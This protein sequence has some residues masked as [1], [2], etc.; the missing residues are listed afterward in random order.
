[1]APGDVIKSGPTVARDGSPRRVLATVGVAVAAAACGAGVALVLTSD[2]DVSA[3]L[4]CNEPLPGRVL[5]VNLSWAEGADAVTM[6]FG[7]GRVVSLDPAV[8]D[9]QRL[10][11]M[12]GH[13]YGTPGRYEISLTARR[14]KSVA[15]SQCN[16]VAAR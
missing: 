13:R 5:N 8:R 1:M 2:R 16:F 6:D 10:A 12:I 3:V 4:T 7:D 14:G 9:N 15:Q 11:D